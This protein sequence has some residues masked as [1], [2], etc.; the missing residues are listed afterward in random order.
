[1]PEPEA[2]TQREVDEMTRAADAASERCGLRFSVFVGG[3]QGEPA[4]YAQQ[5]L[6]GLGNDAAR[7]VLILVDP[8][9]RRVEIVTGSE[10]AQRIDDRACRLTTLAM[11]SSLAAGA[12][13]DA[14]LTG[15]RVLGDAAFWVS[16][17]KASAHSAG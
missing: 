2:F 4:T 7:G 16:R 6:A 12:I 14:V 5:L 13:V 9:G 15:L 11:T 1:V 3:A 10:A 8:Q 17:G